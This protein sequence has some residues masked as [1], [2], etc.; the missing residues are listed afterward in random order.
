MDKLLIVDDNAE[1]RKQLEW[2]LGKSYR[3]LFAED[4]TDALAVFKQQEPKVV[5]LDLGLPPD[6]T[7]VAEGFR[8]WKR[9]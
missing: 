9:C 2:G 5:L 4:R 7:G 1:I 8:V 3:L 6:A